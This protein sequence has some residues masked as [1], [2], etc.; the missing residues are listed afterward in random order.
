MKTATL[1]TAVL[2]LTAAAAFE[3]VPVTTAVLADPVARIAPRDAA[4]G[5]LRAGP[6]AGVRPNRLA[7]SAPGTAAP[8]AAG[9][10]ATP[11]PTELSAPLFLAKL[12]AANA[13]EI[14]AGKLGIERATNPK[15]K[16]AAEMIV[17]D[18]TKAGEELEALVKGRLATEPREVADE[19]TRYDTT[20]RNLRAFNTGG[21]DHAFVSAQIDA[22]KQAIALVKAYAETGDDEELK[23][24]ARSL[25]P[26]LEK[27]LDAVQA[28]PVPA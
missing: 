26:R 14:A 27:H 12:R 22:H 3:A 16:E 18:H 6:A 10:T 17:A 13:F 1:A 5:L 8:G 25:L 21:F 24:F 19:R 7:Q 4:A 15:L 11:Q 2:A 9:A 20:L 28:V 23:A